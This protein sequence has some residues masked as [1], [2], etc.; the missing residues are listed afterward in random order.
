MS[1]QPSN[2]SVLISGV[3]LSYSLFVLILSVTLMEHEIP[4]EQPIQA[5]E[6]AE[7]VKT[8]SEPPK[9]SEIKDVNQKKQDFFQY[10]LPGIN[11]K[12][13]SLNQERNFLL[14]LKNSGYPDVVQ[15]EEI[16]REFTR[17]ANKYK[18]DSLD[19]LLVRVDQIPSSLALA[20]AAI[21]SGWGSSRFAREGNN[22]FGQW[23]YQQGCGLVPRHRIEGA[24]HEV[25]VFNSVNDSINAYFDNIN[26][27][28][29]YQEL[30]QIRADLRQQNQ[31]LS[32][33]ALAEGLEK[34][35]EKG[36][37]YVEVIQTMIASNKLDAY[38]QTLAIK[39]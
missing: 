16:T 18:S 15:A 1:T 39:N 27:N 24:T 13:A 2:K 9:F 20:Q 38:D 22:F 36:Y 23:C 5:E 26:T 17:I 30:R 37:E 28:R 4:V 19:E 11:A 33:T 32:G 14:T 3:F 31:P 25:K 12:N 6:K 8:V 7:P 21:E 29:A 10:L 34:Y 35:S